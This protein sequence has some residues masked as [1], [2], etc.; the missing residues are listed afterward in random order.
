L[1]RFI[2]KLGGIRAVVMPKYPPKKKKTIKKSGV[3]YGGV[4]PP[5]TSKTITTFCNKLDGIDFTRSQK[6]GQ[7]KYGTVYRM[8]PRAIK[9]SNIVQG[10]CPTDFTLE[11]QMSLAIHKALV[12]D[13]LPAHLKRLFGFVVSHC[14]VHSRPPKS[15]CY[16]VMDLIRNYTRSRKLAPHRAYFDEGWVKDGPEIHKT[17]LLCI[18][19][20]HKLLTE[21]TAAALFTAFGHHVAGLARQPFV[22]NLVMVAHLVPVCEELIRQLGVHL[23]EFLHH[24]LLLST[25]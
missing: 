24:F 13:P 2:L 11:Y 9:V 4:W 18:L 6:L 14:F 25:A 5:G 7:G 23:V 19:A 20:R 21:P 22:I 15:R 12:R 17:E 3:R 10:D 16:L 8:G 1:R